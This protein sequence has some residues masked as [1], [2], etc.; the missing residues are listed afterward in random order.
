MG[1]SSSSPQPVDPYA[2]ANAQYGLN[3]QTAQYN[4][5]LNRTGNSNG[6]G[7][8]RAGISPGPTPPRGRRSTAIRRSWLPSSKARYRRL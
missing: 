7:V 4:A 6:V 5:A 8:E 3:T 1:K 2:A